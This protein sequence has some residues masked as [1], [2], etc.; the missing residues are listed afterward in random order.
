MGSN[1]GS[2]LS[3]SNPTKLF[4]PLKRN[5]YYVNG[6]E[7]EK[8]TLEVGQTIDK[9]GDGYWIAT[10][11]S[12]NV[13]PGTR[14]EV[15]YKIQLDL[16][17]S[18]LKAGKTLVVQPL[19]GSDAG[20]P[21]F[22]RFTIE[23]VIVECA[24]NVDTKIT[25]YDGIHATGFS[26]LPPSDGYD[27]VGSPVAIYFN[28][29]SV[30]FDAE[31]ASD[32]SV[33]G[34]FKRYFEAFIDANGNTFTAER[35]RI[36]TAT[37]GI[38][39]SPFGYYVSLNAGANRLFSSS[40]GGLINLV[41]I[42]PKLRGYQYGLINKITLT[43]T[44]VDATSGIYSGYLSKF[45]DI[46]FT[47][48]NQGPLTMGRQ[49][50]VT[51]FYDE[52]N[53]DYADIVFN[54]GFPLT[55]S[56]GSVIDIQ[57]FPT[58]LLDQDLMPLSS[59]QINDSSASPQI[60]QLNDLREFGNISVEE[61]SNE[62]MSFISAAPR[63]LNSSG[64][65]RGF[66]LEQPQPNPNNAEVYLT[67]GNVLVNGSFILMN[68]DTI[69]IPMVQE[70]YSGIFY[71]IN[72]VL[73]VNSRGEY[74]PIPLLNYDATVPAV[75]PNFNGN[76]TNPNRLVTLYN[77]LNGQSYQVPA[78]LFSDL[79]NIRKDLAPLYILTSNVIGGVAPS[80]NITVTDIRRY[81]NDLDTNFPL[82]LTSA[83]TQGNFH[84]PV[85]ILNWIKYNNAFNGTAIVKGATLQ[86]GMIDSVL[87]LDFTSTVSIDGQDDATLTFNQLVTLGSNL[88]FQNINLVFNDGLLVASNTQNLTLDNCHLTIIMPQQP[89][90]SPLKSQYIF[91]IINGNNITITDCTFSIVFGN[92][93]TSGAVFRLTDTNNF[94]YSN[95]SSLS[96]AF[97][98]VVG[99]GTSVPGDIFV[100][101]SSNGV[102]ITDSNFSGNFN[103]FVRITYSN[104]LQIRNFT[105]ASTYSPNNNGALDVYNTTTDPISINTDGLPSVNYTPSNY[106]NSGR[107]YIYAKVTTSVNNIVIDSGIFTYVPGIIE[108]DRFSFINFEL[109]TLSSILSNISITNC[110]FNNIVASGN[111][112]DF[113]PGIAI[114]NTAAAA[115]SSNQQPLLQNIN[116]SNNFG[117]R[118]QMILVTSQTNA[119]QMVYP[120]LVAQ[121]VIIDSN[122]VGTIGY[123]ISSGSK[124]IGI[125]PNV[126]ALSDKS[127][128]LSIQN[129]ICHLITNLDHTGNYW[130]VSK[131]IGNSSADQCS[132][133]SGYVTIANNRTSWI[134]TGIAY[135]ENSSLHILNNSLYAYD[136]AYLVSFNDTIT[137]SINSISSFSYTINSSSYAIFVGSNVTKVPPIQTPGEGNDAALVI[138]GNIVGTGYWLQTTT[139]KFIYQ[140]AL[141]YIMTQSSANINKNILKGVAETSSLGI[142]I[143]AG[144]LNNIITGNL[145]YRQGKTIYTYVGYADLNRFN[146]V[147]SFDGAASTGI[148]T[149]NFFDSPFTNNTATN[150]NNNL[151]AESVVKVNITN[152]SSYSWIVRDN[153]NQTGY[154]SI[155]I[156][157][158]IIPFGGFGYTQTTPYSNNF[159]ITT[160]ASLPHNYA[161]LVLHIHDSE[162]ANA[163]FI[164]WKDTIDKYVPAG[165]RVMLV[166]LG[167]KNPSFGFVTTPTSSPSFDSQVWL[168]LNK[169]VPS[170]TYTNLDPLIPGFGAPID[171]I[172]GG[173]LNVNGPLTTIAS[174]SN[175]VFLPQTTLNVIS[176]SGFS[177]TGSIEV[178]STAGT[179]RIAYTG[180]TGT[181]FTGCTGGAGQIFLGDDVNQP[182][183]VPNLTANITG[184]ILNSTYNTITMVID[185]TTAGSGGTD[186]SSS[187]I[188]GNGAP[189]GLSLDLEYQCINTNAIDFFL[190]PVFIKYRW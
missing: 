89:I 68:A 4:I 23:R 129:N 132:Y 104:N 143:V 161:S 175:N 41:S 185:T 33:A 189:F 61:L 176:T 2:A 75:S 146:G 26:P 70:L 31:N 156:P 44:S 12:V 36:S 42:S 93:T 154:L 85:S 188:S 180:T 148:V 57:L 38:S 119:G 25:V 150:I 18:N 66:D 53:V 27:T 135:E 60:T 103:M 122:V 166:Q 51:R 37:S 58:L 76:P 79:V 62:A 19:P 170:L 137:N 69:I 30:S 24:P 177:S 97:K 108:N 99:S 17:T 63:L 59:C 72:W 158:G 147:Y 101:I 110:E 121:D 187:F 118:N 165:A 20:L 34:P 65:I 163:R 92:N 109:S 157:A 48:S 124:T 183:N 169:Y 127:V 115:T 22:G 86:T 21:D 106:V 49:G 40:I 138:S 186:I 155:P 8:L 80:I 91:D 116:I 141:G 179:E 173:V 67:G 149:N 81:V 114:V 82:R 39:V 29:D 6:T 50:Q 172:D 181:S 164:G 94:V 113:R 105:L 14:T 120:G 55:I 9:F 15:T 77:V 112:D 16:S 130:L 162:G 134:H 43:L 28:S 140:Y 117:N 184:A 153:K 35:A 144:G 174:G 142:L 159:Y 98:N 151:D 128:G 54:L 111:T 1:Y 64:V 78:I 52:T 136:P 125:A 87:D 139:T 167:F 178:T 107:G 84:S 45:D 171:S 56:N 11:D 13:I 3:A 46:V 71:N 100:L 90:L 83:N 32:L 74:Q 126:N 96:V 123:C 10:I 133:P 47:Y 7:R 152:G 102:T 160:A 145:I 95:N 131:V 73:C 190:S 182:T 88:T 5:T 168:T